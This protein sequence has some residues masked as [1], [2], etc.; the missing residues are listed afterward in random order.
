MF[1]KHDNL[2]STKSTRSSSQWVLAIFWPKW[3]FWFI[4]AVHGNK[5]VRDELPY[6]QFLDK[7]LI[8][9]EPPLLCIEIH[10][11]PMLKELTACNDYF[12]VYQDSWKFPMGPDLRNQP[13]IRR[14]PNPTVHRIFVLIS[15]FLYWFNLNKVTSDF[16]LFLDQFSKKIW[17][18]GI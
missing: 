13:K 9:D 1:E 6:L 10:F 16:Q 5:S 12:C 8:M 7:L 18:A 4:K 17:F 11:E 2:K 14:L 3:S 15:T